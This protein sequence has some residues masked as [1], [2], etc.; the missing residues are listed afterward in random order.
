MLMKVQGL[1]IAESSNKEASSIDT[2][3][4]KL[5]CKEAS[6]KQ[7]DTSRDELVRQLKV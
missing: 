7:G 4:I 5:S 1:R 6:L 2:L 3:E